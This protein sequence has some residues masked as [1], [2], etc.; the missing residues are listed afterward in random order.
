MHLNEKAVSVWGY[1]YLFGERKSVISSVSID[2]ISEDKKDVKVSVK[3]KVLSDICLM[4]LVNM[5]L[6]HQNLQKR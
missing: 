6:F 5:F 4:A 1:Y 3:C 2:I